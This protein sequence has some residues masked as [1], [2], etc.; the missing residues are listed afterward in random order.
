VIKNVFVA[1]DRRWFLTGKEGLNLVGKR[2]FEG[3]KK[4]SG[5]GRE[6]VID[7]KELRKIHFQNILIVDRWIRAEELFAVE[8][9]LI[10]SE[11]ISDV[12]VDWVCQWYLE[13][14]AEFE[15]HSIVCHA[16]CWLGGLGLG[17]WTYDAGG[18]FRP[19]IRDNRY[20]STD[21]I[22]E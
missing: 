7:W 16:I 4:F 2:I 12:V 15:S 17:F 20:V 11:T 13:S 3:L 5:Q 18:I 19:D 14:S 9:D 8:K 10:Q 21:C 6:S 1:R 22:G